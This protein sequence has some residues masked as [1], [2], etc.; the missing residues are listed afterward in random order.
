MN[1]NKIPI[2]ATGI[3]FSIKIDGVEKARGRLYIMNND[4]HE[5]PFGFIEDLFVHEQ[6]RSCG[7]GSKIVQEMIEEAKKLGCYKIVATSRF[8]RENIHKFYEKNGFRKYGYEFRLEL[9]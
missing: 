9:K 3:R 5:E 8:E 1:L 7:Y 2:T 4:L 6:V